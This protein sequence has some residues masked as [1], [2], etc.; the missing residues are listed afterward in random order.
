MSTWV[1]IFVR[2]SYGVGSSNGVSRRSSISDGTDDSIFPKI[3][4]F[5][6]I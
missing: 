5:F 6:Y 3:E 1:M 2:R 4:C